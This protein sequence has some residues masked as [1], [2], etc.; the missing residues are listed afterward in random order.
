METLGGV[1]EPPLQ[2]EMV[3]AAA[4]QMPGRKEV[5]ENMEAPEY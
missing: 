1:D 2:P 4:M 3:S 5:F